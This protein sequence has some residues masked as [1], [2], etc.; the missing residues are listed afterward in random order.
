MTTRVEY[1]DTFT[2]ML[3]PL[4]QPETTSIASVETQKAQFNQ[5]EISEAQNQGTTH[6]CVNVYNP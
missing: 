3:L 2:E 5:T 4:K 6:I 1:Q